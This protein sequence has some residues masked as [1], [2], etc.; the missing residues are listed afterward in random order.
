MA[1]IINH[2]KKNSYNKKQKKKA[3]KYAKNFTWE[4]CTKDTLKL[5]KKIL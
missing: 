3:I 1:Q 5:Y 4:K 2:L